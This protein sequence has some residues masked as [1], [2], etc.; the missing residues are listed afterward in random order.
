MV[1]WIDGEAIFAPLA[2]FGRI[3]LAVSGGPDSLALLL[4]AADLSPERRTANTIALLSIRSIM[5]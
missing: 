5:D 2:E 3:G 4:L 1:N